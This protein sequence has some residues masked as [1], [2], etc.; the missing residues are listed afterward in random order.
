MS[1]KKTL[2]AHGRKALEPL[3]R[4]TRHNDSRYE[5]GVPWKDDT[6][7]P[8]NYFLVKAQLQPLENRFQQ[9]P[10]LVCRYNQTIEAD[11]EKRFVEETQRQPNFMN[12]QLWYLSHHPVELKLKKKVKRVTNAAS[13][14]KGHSLSKALL[15]GPDL[16]CR[17]V[18][19]L[20]RFRQYKIAV[21][22]DIEAMFMQV[23]IRSQD[24]DALRFLCNKD[25]EDKIF[26]Y[27]R[28]IFG[29][30]CYPS[31]AVCINS[32]DVQKIINQA[33][34]YPTQS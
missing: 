5:I 7:L 19:L 3:K 17:L 1:G 12:S 11:I 6:K 15:T 33:I 34:P 8:N 31:C 18:G 22:G 2:T 29:A 24:Q 13:V 21:T 20:L 4:T 10:D 9:E 25:E 30:T 23:A 26:K 14:Y 28:L 32:T 16:L 27:K